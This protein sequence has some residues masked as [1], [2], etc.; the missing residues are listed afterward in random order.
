MKAFLTNFLNIRHLI[1]YL[2]VSLTVM[3][4]LNNKVEVEPITPPV[5]LTIYEKMI[6]QYKG[7]WTNVEYSGS[8]NTHNKT[9]QDG[10][11]D[12]YFNQDSSDIIPS[13][14]NTVGLSWFD[15]STMTTDHIYYRTESNTSAYYAWF[16]YNN[17]SMVYVEHHFWP[18]GDEKECTF[19]G[20]IE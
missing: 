5:E 13:F 11:V 15:D 8:N 2:V 6:G 7:E 16:Y 19:N 9:I 4:C 17:D 10:T 12:L 20:K 14:F 3:S 18:T 1:L